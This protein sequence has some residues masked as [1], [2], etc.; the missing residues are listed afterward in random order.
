MSV[1]CQTQTSN[2]KGH[3]DAHEK[4][5]PGAALKFD[6][7]DRGSDCY[8]CWLELATKRCAQQQKGYFNEVLIELNLVFVGFSKTRIEP[9]VGPDSI[10]I[11]LK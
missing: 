9:L 4:K 10:V 7:D 5:P 6:P 1:L 11:G 2:C 8:Q 3:S